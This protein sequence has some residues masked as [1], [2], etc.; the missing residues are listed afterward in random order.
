[1]KSLSLPPGISIP[2]WSVRDAVQDLLTLLWRTHIP[3][4]R[5]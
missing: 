5:L 1:M 2:A 4:W 3:L